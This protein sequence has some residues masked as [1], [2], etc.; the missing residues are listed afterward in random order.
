M[1]WLPK[2]RGHRQVRGRYTG[3]LDPAVWPATSATQPC[4]PGSRLANIFQRAD[5]AADAQGHEDHLGRPPH[6]V[7]HDVAILVAGRDV[8]EDQLIGPFLFIPGSHGN[9]IARI[10]QVEK[11]RSLDDPS[12]VNVKAW[13][14]TASRAW[15]ANGGEEGLNRSGRTGCRQRIAADRFAQTLNLSSPTPRVNRRGCSAC[16]QPRNPNRRTAITAPQDR[17]RSQ[18]SSSADFLS[19]SIAPN[20]AR[21]FD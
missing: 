19:R 16:R 13:N 12:S 17:C 15:K 5:A 7:E 9:R 3:L 1:H 6:H 2:P 10:A 21:L 20:P 8:E 14:H 11:V 18:R 4:R